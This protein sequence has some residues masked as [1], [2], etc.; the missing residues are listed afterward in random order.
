MWVHRQRQTSWRGE[1][2]GEVQE[3]SAGT[4]QE[5]CGFIVSAGE[6]RGETRAEKWR[7]KVGSSSPENCVRERTEP[8]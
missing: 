1:G 2:S 7:N 8:P 3:Q 4:L 5:H 6:L